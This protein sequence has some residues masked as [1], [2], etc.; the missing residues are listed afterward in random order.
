MVELF[1]LQVEE[2][3]HFI[4]ESGFINKNCF[5]ELCDFTETQYTFIIGWNRSADPSQRCR[6]VAASN[7]PTKPEGM[8]IV[9]YWAPWLDKKHP[10]PAKP[11]ELRW[12][13]GGEEVD[14]PGPHMFEGKMTR[15]TS[16]TFIPGKLSD[17]PDLAQS[18]YD[19]R[20]ASQPEELRRAYRDGIFDTTVKTDAFQVIPTEWVMAA[21]ERWSPAIP[22]GVPMSA[23]AADIAQGGE[24]DTVLAY[25]YGGWYAPLVTKPGAETKD[26]ASVAG[27]ITAHRRNQCDVILDMTGGYGGGTY[28]VLKSNGIEVRC[29][30][31]YDT[32]SLRSREG[33]YKFFNARAAAYWKFREALDPNQDGGSQIALP[34]SHDLMIDLVTPKWELTPQGIKITPKE[35]IVELLR[36][37][38]DKGDAVVSCWTAGP[39]VYRAMLD[40]NLREQGIVGQP[41]KIVDLGTRRQV[42]IVGS[43]RHG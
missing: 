13:L 17:N 36:R 6:V 35:K 19:A 29:F 37:S 28:E 2:V 18:N 24:D 23:L 15:A 42:S 22:Y 25:R 34:E 7:P 3:N 41:S 43:R 14:G 40:A 16:R 32:S 27:L 38:T 26:G 5:D 8:W 10:R 39:K 20:L 12:F 21:F 9:K 31:G 4:T 11:G 33:Q 30:R 1:D